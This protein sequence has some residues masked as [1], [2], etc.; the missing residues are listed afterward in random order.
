MEMRRKRKREMD[1]V[2]AY[3]VEVLKPF[4]KPKTLE[5]EAL[6]PY[7]SDMQIALKIGLLDRRRLWDYKR[8]AALFIPEKYQR[9]LDENTGGIKKKKSLLC[10]DD[11]SVMFRIRYLVKTY[12]MTETQSLMSESSVKDLILDS[13]IEDIDFAKQVKEIYENANH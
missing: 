5:I 9:L 11:V 4:P 10:E 2:P 3:P 12:G 8:L 1:L 13:Q 6:S 7:L